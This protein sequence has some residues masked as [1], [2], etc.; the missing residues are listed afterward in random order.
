VTPTR[1]VNTDFTPDATRPCLVGYSFQLHT[2]LTLIGTSSAQVT[3]LADPGPGTPTTVRS[4]A[5]HQINIGVGITVNQQ[6]D[7]IS[8]VYAMIPANWVCRLVPS[9]SNG[10]TVTSIAQVEVPLTP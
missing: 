7:V 10:G 6:S 9:T 4:R 1:A 8:S 5:M 2:V 3:L